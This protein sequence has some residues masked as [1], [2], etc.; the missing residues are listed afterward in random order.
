MHIIPNHTAMTAA[1][2][3]LSPEIITH[4]ELRPMTAKMRLDNYR[5]KLDAA[6]SAGHGVSCEVAAQPNNTETVWSHNS[7]TLPGNAIITFLR[8]GG[9]K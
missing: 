8:R 7:V 1:E 9:A 6:L 2:M 5:D 4:H 3:G